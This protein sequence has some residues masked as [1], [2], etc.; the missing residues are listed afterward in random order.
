MHETE[1]QADDLQLWLYTILWRYD[2]VAGIGWKLWSSC[3]SSDYFDR[4]N[5][6]AIFSQYMMSDGYQYSM[7]VGRLCSRC[8]A[9][10]DEIYSDLLDISS[11][12]RELPSENRENLLRLIDNLEEAANFM[13]PAY[14]SADSCRDILINDREKVGYGGFDSI[15]GNDIGSSS[16]IRSKCSSIF[17]STLSTPLDSIVQTIALDLNNIASQIASDLDLG[18]NSHF[19]MRDENG[20]MIRSAIQALEQC[21]CSVL[22]FYS[23][24]VS[25]LCWY[26]DT[27]K[28]EVLELQKALNTISSSGMLTEDGVYGEKTSAKYHD[29]LSGLT[30]G[31]FP[32]LTYINPLRS[33]LSG[34][35]VV[36]KTT[37]SGQVFSQIFVDGTKWPVFRADRHRYGADLNFA[38][39]NVDAPDGAPA[40]Q[41]SL[42]K[43]LDHKGISDDAYDLL[44][45]FDDTAKIV[46]IGGKVLL[47]AGVVIDAL[48]L[49]ES[50][51]TDLS[52]ADQKL[53][54][55]TATTSISI[56]GSW[57]GGA[58][59]A[60]AGTALG[61]G[62]GTAIL[63]GL[64]T[65]IGGV[66]GGLV[67]G[68]V[69]SSAGSSLGEWIVDITDVWE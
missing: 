18:V 22:S 16:Y 25:Q 56:V 9:V 24:K 2:H 7:A 28:D 31:S 66:V 15:W 27:P 50:I 23:T 26:R 35:R 39:I 65:A 46:K 37:K 68:V 12:F 67:L 57:G 42:A 13:F 47:A 52:D 20:D 69:G 53:G 5:Q 40:W 54:K 44:K 3:C 55:M 32:S 4:L 30:H 60:K 58:L 17:S 36:S 8:V 45:N 38:H 48:E 1:Q 14:T 49:A 29:L 19:Y 62:I 21:N 43:H 64:G 34:V 10:I 11:T 59:G 41:K 51:H 63:P 6:E 61:A 33:S